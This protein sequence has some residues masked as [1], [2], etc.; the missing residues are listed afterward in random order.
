AL[1]AMRQDEALF[2]P[3]EKH[4]MVAGHGAATDSRIADA[5]RLARKAGAAAAELLL[6]IH[7]SAPLDGAAEVEGRARR[8]IG[9]VAVMGLDDLG[10]PVV[11]AKD[12]G[13]ALDQVG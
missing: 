6:G 2:G 4:V 12:A 7:P 5:S 8:C 10:V 1:G 9:L 11:R 3:E 13:R